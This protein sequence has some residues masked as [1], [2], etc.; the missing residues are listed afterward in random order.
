MNLTTKMKTLRTT[1]TRLLP[2]ALVLALTSC[3]QTAES[4]EPQ[5]SY[6]I[7][8]NYL[9]RLE[10]PFTDLSP[11]ERESEWGKEYHIALTFAKRLDLYRSISTFER[12][13]ILIPHALQERL[14]EIDYYIAL[15]YYI[16]KKYDDL[17]DHFEH[18]ELRYI[19]QEFPA[20]HDLL[21][22]LNEAYLKNE[23]PDKA[24]S[25]MEMLHHTYPQTGEKIALSTELRAADIPSLKKRETPEVSTLLSS[26]EINKKSIR[27]AK[28]L[29]GVLPGAGYLYL[30][31]K[32]TALTAF[33]LNT[34]FVY[35][36]YEFFHRGYPAA[37]AIFAS[38]EAGWYIGGIYGVGESA[39]LYN[40][41]VYEETTY[42]YM[43]QNRLFPILRIT[44]GF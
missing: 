1:L 33:L 24:A 35:A 31:Q 32:Q 44:H 2:L 14:W 8:D 36:A 43:Q 41:R 30:G 27:T 39:K 42:P 12:A 37:G 5:L 21:V 20:Y 7:Q 11:L 13:K 38:F 18:S 3:D 34:T 25:V 22:M 26:Y 23:E 19:T 29:N 9:K 10:S 17:V 4:I 28:V 6:T 16:S 15:C 40:E